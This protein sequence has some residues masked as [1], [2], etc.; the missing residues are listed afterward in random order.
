[1]TRANHAAVQTPRRLVRGLLISIALN[2]A[3]PLI[4]YRLTKRYL[5][6]SEVIALSVAALFPLVMSMVDLIR[7][8]TLDPVA[9]LVLMSIVVSMLGV[10]LGGSAKLLLIRESLF[11]GAFGIACFVSLA[12]PRPLMFYFGRHFTTG[13]DPERIAQFD[14]GWQRP[15]FRYVNRLITAV[16][17][18]MS[19]AEFVIRVVLVYTLPAAV[20]LVI[21]PIISGG[22]VIA[23]I[24]WTFAYVARVRRLGAATEPKMSAPA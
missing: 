7:S 3:I 21:S 18:T 4:L 17:G 23:T 5:T 8:R 1:M 12:L 14:A 9:L 19:T 11:T 24:V 10:G 13:R 6:G 22:I 2:A 16:W 20:V 15:H